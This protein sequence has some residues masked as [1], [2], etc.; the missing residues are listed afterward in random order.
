MCQTRV[1]TS[2]GKTVISNCTNCKTYYIWHHNL[3]LTF[4]VNGFA[5][6]RETVNSISF[7]SNSL[8]F[9]D[10]HDRIILHTPNDDISFAFDAGELEDFRAAILE[11]EY[12]NEV[13]L[14]MERGAGDAGG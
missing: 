2:K 13:Y 10:G 6:F 1:L 14:L 9:P 8:P 5:S 3:V 7:D 12:M 11:A 4:P